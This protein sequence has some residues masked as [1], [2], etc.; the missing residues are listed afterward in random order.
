MKITQ[1]SIGLGGSNSQSILTVIE[2]HVTGQVM[3]GF[4]RTT[5]IF[6]AFGFVKALS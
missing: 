1:S 3:A 4:G 6:Q 2:W 5:F